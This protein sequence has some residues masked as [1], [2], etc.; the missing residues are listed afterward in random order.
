VPRLFDLYASLSPLYKEEE[1][2]CVM[3]PSMGNK[4]DVSVE[5]L[6][7]DPCRVRA[8]FDSGRLAVQR[9]A[10][11]VPAGDSPGPEPI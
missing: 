6:P 11:K 9:H 3:L 4:H 2:E 8:P 7:G 10:P 5:L 1:G